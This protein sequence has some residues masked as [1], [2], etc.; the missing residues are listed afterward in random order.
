MN[1][2]TLRFSNFIASS[3]FFRLSMLFLIVSAGWIALTGQFPMAFDEDFHLGLIRIYASHL[4]PFLSGQPANGDA[5]GA[6]A[7]DPSFLY[8]YLMSFPYRLIS[9]ISHNEQDQVLILRAINI[10]L[11]TSCLPLYKKLLI[12]TGSSVKL[13][14]ICIAVFVLIPISP[15]LA[16]QINYDNLILPLTAL[17][18]YSALRLTEAGVKDDTTK[19]LLIVIAL[20]FAGCLI[21]F[22]FIPIF[23]GVIAWLIWMM[24]P[25][26]KSIRL[27]ASNI[28]HRANKPV[29]ALL[30]IGI[31]LLSVAGV[32]RYG[33]N[34]IRHHDPIPE[35][36]KVLSLEHCQYYGPYIRDYNFAQ[37]K[38]N[39]D[40]NP[41]RYT[42]LWFK[43][44]WI[45][46]FFAV[47]G[48]KTQ[49]QT[50]GPLAIPAIAALVLLSI[51]LIALLF[52]AKALAAKSLPPILLLIGV[53]LIYI[54][55]VW[56][57]EYKAYLHT[58]VPVAIN[59]R[60][61]LP[62]ILLLMYPAA[63]AACQILKRDIYKLA[64]AAIALLALAWGGGSG[65]YILRSNDSWYW[66]NAVTKDAN[67]VYQR[68][69]GPVTPGYGTPN[70][71]L[72]YL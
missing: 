40:T 60:Y 11:F 17:L 42:K 61:L 46:S 39:S 8:H 49:F 62:V 44:M 10:A 51:G 65:T 14:N 41:V 38:S 12:K 68:V 2:I 16:A 63:E 37:N 71:F 70:A 35:C 13:A 31:F 21:K 55:A 30:L 45:R 32:Q 72:R 50:R 67:H 5:Y 34:I 7:R 43:G 6:V 29:I 15:L 36:G 54:A 3:L 59:G 64:F 20:G 47:D 25:N 66:S 26:L 69:F 1:H 53:S 28:L 22:A 23:F 56:L 4:S 9:L 48:P 52:Q 18:L 58:G 24:R 57:Q 27:T 33:V 19:Q